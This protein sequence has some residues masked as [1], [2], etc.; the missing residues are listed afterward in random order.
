MGLFINRLIEEGQKMA[1]IIY[2]DDLT[3]GFCFVL[4]VVTRG[5]S[6]GVVSDLRR[7]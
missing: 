5:A 7:R 1:D 3:K 4:W 2:A 6:V